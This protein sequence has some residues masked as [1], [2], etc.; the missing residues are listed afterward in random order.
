MWWNG[1]FPCSFIITKLISSFLAY[2]VQYKL[3]NI[4]LLIG[5]HKYLFVKSTVISVPV[6]HFQ[7]SQN[8]RKHPFYIYYF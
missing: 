7:A 3:P 2:I 4:N 5:A 1:L 6:Y 8:Q